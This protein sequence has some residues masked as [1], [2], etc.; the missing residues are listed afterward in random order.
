V[1]HLAREA[2]YATSLLVTE[3]EPNPSFPGAVLLT[4]EPCPNCGKVHHHGNPRPEPDADGTFGHRSAH[5]DDVDAPGYML[6]AADL[7]VEGPL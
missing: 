5:C 2:K 4:T 3:I 1:R 6:Q 7:Y